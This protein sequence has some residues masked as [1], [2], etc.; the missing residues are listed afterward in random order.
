MDVLLANKKQKSEVVILFFAFLKSYS[1]VTDFA[2]FRGWS[3]F[4]SSITAMWYDSNCNGMVVSN[5]DNASI[6]SGTSIISLLFVS[7]DGGRLFD[8]DMGS[9]DSVEVCITSVGNFVSLLLSYLHWTE[10]KTRM[11][12]IT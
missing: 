7:V 3:T 5:G 11:K 12:L 10:K 9:I 1:T 4:L 2:K 6:V 8:W